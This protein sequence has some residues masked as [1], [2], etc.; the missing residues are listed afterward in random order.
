MLWSSLFYLAFTSPQG[1][2]LKKE[3]KIPEGYKPFSSAVFG[4]AKKVKL[5]RRLNE[6]AM[7]L[8]IS[9]KSLS[10]TAQRNPEVV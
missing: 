8:L 1:A 4:Y 10:L 6:S 7:L 5:L 3:L 2:E 9:N